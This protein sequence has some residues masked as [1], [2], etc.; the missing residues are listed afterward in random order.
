YVSA[1]AWPEDHKVCVKALAEG[2][3]L[4]PQKIKTVELLGYGKVSFTRNADNLI[5]TL[6]EKLNNIMPVLKIKK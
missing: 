1:L 2:S 3:P 6:P 5:V 4:F